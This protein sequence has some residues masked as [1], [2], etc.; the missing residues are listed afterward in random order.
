MA[1]I[2]ISQLRKWRVTGIWCLACDDTACKKQS[3]DSNPGLSDLRDQLFLVLGGVQGGWE[4]LGRAKGLGW[5]SSFVRS[6]CALSRGARIT[7]PPSAGYIVFILVF[8]IM[9]VFIFLMAFN[10][11]WLSYWM[12][13]GSGV[14]AVLGASGSSDD[15]STGPGPPVLR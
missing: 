2:A 3:Q 13:Q 9:V 10:V 1:T 4:G 11:W 15:Q 7:A 5:T 6:C 14:S 12:E 8:F